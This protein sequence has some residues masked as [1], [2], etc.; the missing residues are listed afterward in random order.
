MCTLHSVLVMCICIID[1]AEFGA[2]HTVEKCIARMMK[3]FLDSSLEE[4][5]RQAVLLRVDPNVS[6]K[7]LIFKFSSN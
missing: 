7:L 5:A 4:L 3:A 2:V 1:C 6:I